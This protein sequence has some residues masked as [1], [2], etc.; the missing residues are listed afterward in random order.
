MDRNIVD[1]HHVI[2]RTL[3]RLPSSDTHAPNSYV[4]TVH[5]ILLDDGSVMYQCNYPDTECNYA[6]LGLRSVMSH[7]RAHS[8][9]IA[10]RKQ[11]RAVEERAAVNAVN[12]QRGAEA[13]RERVEHVREIGLAQTLRDVADSLIDVSKTLRAAARCVSFEVDITP[14]ELTRLRNDAAALETLRDVIRHA[15]R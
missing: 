12:R 9:K 5:E 3:A 10:M 1:S 6:R 11:R 4:R 15:G 13:N 7:Q 2:E 14:E 8:A